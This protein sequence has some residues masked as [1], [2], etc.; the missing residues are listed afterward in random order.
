MILM[1]IFILLLSVGIALLFINAKTDLYIPEAPFLV[2]TVGGSFGLLFVVFVLICVSQP[3]Y[4]EG[5]ISDYNIERLGIERNY[6]E[7]INSHD[8]HQRLSALAKITAW[9]ADVKSYKSYSQNPI[10]GDFFPEEVANNMEYID[11]ENLEEINE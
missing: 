1:M 10:T 5:K 9:N 2:C 6:I 11:I 7:S 8:K 4:I 3:S